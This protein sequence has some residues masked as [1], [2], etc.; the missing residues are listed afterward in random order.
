MTTT[1]DLPDI[2]RHPDIQ[3]RTRQFHAVRTAFKF[4]RLQRTMWQ[5][6][7]QRP[8]FQVRKTSTHHVAGP[9]STA[10]L[11][12]SGDFTVPYG[13]PLVQG[14]SFKLWRLPHTLHFR[15]YF[16]KM[17]TLFLFSPV[18]HFSLQFSLGAYN[19]LFVC[20]I[21]RIVSFFCVYILDI[22]F[23]FCPRSY[24]VLYFLMFALLRVHS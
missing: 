9:L 21:F 6:H 12:S 18:T 8:S 5:A 17:F 1:I 11:S 7:C 10:L 3:W 19:F 23:S 2:V 14:P 24:S 13:R 16:A 20:H 22:F 4:G 15:S